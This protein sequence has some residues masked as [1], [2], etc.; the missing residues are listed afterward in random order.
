M[1]RCSDSFYFEEFSKRA[2]LGYIAIPHG[3]ALVVRPHSRDP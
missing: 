3:A 2:N 1:N